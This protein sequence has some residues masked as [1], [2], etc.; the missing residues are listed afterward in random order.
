MYLRLKN[1]LD[2]EGFSALFGEGGKKPVFDKMME[3]I[4]MLDAA[5]GVGRESYAMGG[6]LLFFPT[7]D[8]YKSSIDKLAE[9][10]HFDPWIYEFNDSIWEDISTGVEW[11]R[12]H[13]QLS[14]DDALV[15]YYPTTV[16]TREGR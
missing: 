11:R 15:M 7:E 16:T 6:Y 5:Y 9:V 13:Y 10:Y 4:Q 8:D 2:L 12:Q 3:D 14:S 1:K